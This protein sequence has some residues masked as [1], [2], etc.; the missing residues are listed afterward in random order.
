ME[1]VRKTNIKA[2]KVL[3][4]LSSIINGKVTQMDIR[5]ISIEDLL[6]REPVEIDAE[7]VSSYITNK[8]Y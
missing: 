6:G 4:G 3:P 2:V 5:N 8:I 1:F 7:K